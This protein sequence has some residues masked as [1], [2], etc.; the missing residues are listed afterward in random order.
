MLNKT[1]KLAA[2]ALVATATLAPTAAQAQ[3]YAGD[4]YHASFDRVD[5]RRDGRRGYR[6][7]D[8][9]YRSGYRDYNR[10]RGYGYGDYDRGDR[11]SHYRGRRC[12]NGTGGTIIGAIAGG[13]LGNTVVGRRG[14]QTAG[15][16]VGAG[17]GALA[18]RAVDRDC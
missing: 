4:G 2:A 8:R 5:Y 15:T 10:G 16:I 14:D 1:L 17:V 13:L 6:D 11:R 12:D 3:Y 9:G 18:G 7:Y